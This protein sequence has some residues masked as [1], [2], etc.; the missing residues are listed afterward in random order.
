MAVEGAT[1]G[2][3]GNSIIKK[4]GEIAWTGLPLPQGQEF[5]L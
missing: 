2:R 4:Q 1:D 3:G 5:S